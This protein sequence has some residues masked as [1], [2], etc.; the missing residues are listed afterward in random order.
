M[1]RILQNKHGMCALSNVGLFVGFTFLGAAYEL[2][3]NPEYFLRFF[4]G[5]KIF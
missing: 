2:L 5:P 4:D 1:F 3:R